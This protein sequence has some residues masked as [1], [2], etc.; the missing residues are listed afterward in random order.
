MNI[1]VK[2]LD[3]SVIYNFKNK[4]WHNLIFLIDSTG[5][6]VYVIVS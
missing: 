6:I 1:L 4:Y 2:L 5:V 3:V